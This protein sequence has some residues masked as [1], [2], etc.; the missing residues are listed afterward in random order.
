MEGLHRSA[1]LHSLSLRSIWDPAEI[2][3]RCQ[4]RKG[5]IIVIIQRL[6][7]CAGQPALRAIIKKRCPAV[8]TQ[9]KLRDVKCRTIRIDITQLR[10]HLSVPTRGGQ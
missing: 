3:L 10:R 4:R 2:D 6:Q 8:Q 9:K 1:K 7:D 5:A